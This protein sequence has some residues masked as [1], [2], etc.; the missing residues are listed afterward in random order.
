MVENEEDEVDDE[1]RGH[2]EVLAADDAEEELEGGVPLLG[3]AGDLGDGD[4]E[5]GVLPRRGL[6]RV[7]PEA[8][9]KAENNVDTIW[10]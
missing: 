2:V 7:R 6:L 1:V 8:E 4:E 10:K 9:M 5:P 3:V